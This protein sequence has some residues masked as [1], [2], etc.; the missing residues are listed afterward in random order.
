ML[1]RLEIIQSFAVCAVVSGSLLELS[2]DRI[3][4]LH[5]GFIGVVKSA[6]CILHFYTSSLMMTTFYLEDLRTL[7]EFHHTLTMNTYCFRL[8]LAICAKGQVNPAKQFSSAYKAAVPTD[9]WML[10]LLLLKRPA[11]Y[12]LESERSWLHIRVEA[13]SMGWL[14]PICLGSFSLYILH[15]PRHK[16][17]HDLLLSLVFPS[18][19]VSWHRGR[20][21]GEAITDPALSD[22]TSRAWRRHCGP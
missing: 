13:H 10:L 22:I 5:S 4:L 20:R 21:C 8:S 18:S 7:F 14:I 19:L 1:A 9:D 6:A 2:N 3:H 16:L 12:L 15:S 17:Q 11:C